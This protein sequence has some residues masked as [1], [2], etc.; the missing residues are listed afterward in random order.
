MRRSVAACLIGLV[1]AGLSIPVVQ[2]WRSESL[3]RLRECRAEIPSTGRAY[4]ESPCASMRLSVPALS[5]ISR[6]EV[7]TA[8]GRADYCFDQPSVSV[9]NTKSL[10]PGWAFFYLPVG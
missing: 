10:H 6:A 7:E 9:Q 8:L 1:I 3:D 4:F 2:H 5:G